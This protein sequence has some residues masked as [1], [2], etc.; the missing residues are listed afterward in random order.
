MTNKRKKSANNKKAQKLAKQINPQSSDDSSDEEADN[1]NEPK[2]EP[3]AKWN[4]FQKFLQSNSMTRRANF[5]VGAK[6]PRFFPKM[7]QS[8]K[9]LDLSTILAKD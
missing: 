3:N 7:N 1:Q 4:L 8:S 6:N 9:G 2:F 5:F